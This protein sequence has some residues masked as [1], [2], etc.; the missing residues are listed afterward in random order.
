MSKSLLDYGR[1]DSLEEIFNKIDAVTSVELLEIANQNFDLA[2]LSMLT[3]MP[4]E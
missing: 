4:T 3:F 1:V 2:Q